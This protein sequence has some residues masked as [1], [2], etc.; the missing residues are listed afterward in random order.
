MSKLNKKSSWGRTFKFKIV[1]YMNKQFKLR[2]MKTK[3][4]NISKLMLLL[5]VIAFTLTSCEDDGVVEDTTLDQAITADSPLATQMKNMVSPNSAANSIICV[6]FVYPITVNTYDINNQVTSTT[7][8]N[9]DTELDAF[10][11]TL[12]NSQ[13]IG[14]VFPISLDTVNGIVTVADETDL[15]NELQIAY[16]ACYTN[17][18][19]GSGGGS[20]GGNSPGSGTAGLLFCD[21][22]N[23]QV[24]TINLDDIFGWSLGVNDTVAYYATDADAQAETNALSSIINMNLGT[25]YNIY[26]R[27]DEFSPNIP[28]PGLTTTILPISYELVPCP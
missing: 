27:T 26:V 20:G 22:N 18:S 19:G 17:G 3:I 9:N 4:S 16:D 13:F 21:T 25:V 24:E 28:A 1:L 5:L 15:F 10:F 2:I 23:D 8:V 7:T 14:F 12:S 11:V 6:D